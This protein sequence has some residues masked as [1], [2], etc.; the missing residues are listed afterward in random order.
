[1]NMIWKEIRVFV[2]F[3]TAPA[4]VVSTLIML[5]LGLAFVAPPIVWAIETWALYW[6]PTWG[7]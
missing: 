7:S 3:A 1:M 4:I 5:A 2:E 6:C